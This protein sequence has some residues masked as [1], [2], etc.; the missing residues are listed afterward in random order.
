MYGHEERCIVF[1][2]KHEEKEHMRDLDTDGRI[3]LK[4]ILKTEVK[5]MDWSDLAPDRGK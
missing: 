2:G 1:W 5:C 4:L 3:I